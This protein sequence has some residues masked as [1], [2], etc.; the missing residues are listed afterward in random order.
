MKEDV[1]K[2]GRIF[3]GVGS[4]SRNEWEGIDVKGHCL[5]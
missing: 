4:Y 2:R 5:Q 3:W 1:K